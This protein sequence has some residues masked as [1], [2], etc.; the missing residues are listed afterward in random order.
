MSINLSLDPPRLIIYL[1]VSL[2][3]SVLPLLS[4]LEFLTMVGSL[5]E[6][7]SFSS[8][9]ASFLLL[10]LRM[11]PVPPMVRLK[12]FFPSSRSAA[13]LSNKLISFFP[14]S[15]IC[16][17]SSVSLPSWYLARYSQY[18]IVILFLSRRCS[19]AQSFS[20]V[21]FPNI[22]AASTIILCSGSYFLTWLEVLFLE[23]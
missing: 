1:G 18:A 9:P 15:I 14:F 8:G 6:F 7:L 12:T 10:F 22:S 16:N 4:I 20:G 17:S 5:I 23:T 11:L 2:L 19:I 3:L 21:M 13:V